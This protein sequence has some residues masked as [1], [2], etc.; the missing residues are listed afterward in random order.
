MKPLRRKISL[1][2]TKMNWNINRIELKKDDE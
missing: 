1:T 2:S